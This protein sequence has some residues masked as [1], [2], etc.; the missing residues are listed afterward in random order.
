MQCTLV[1]VTAAI[2]PY[3]SSHRQL[4]LVAAA[5]PQTCAISCPVFVHTYPS[6][7]TYYHPLTIAMYGSSSDGPREPF[8]PLFWLKLC[9]PLLEYLAVAGSVFG[10]F[11]CKR[12]N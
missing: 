10:N 3:A 11:A 8:L 9:L 5:L 2:A 1:L 4:K 7:A 6:I 12:C